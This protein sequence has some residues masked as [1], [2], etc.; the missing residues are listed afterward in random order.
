[1]KLKALTQNLFKQIFRFAR[2]PFYGKFGINSGVMLMNLTQM[3]A[4]K[5]EQQLL[6]IYEKY[7]LNLVFGDQ[8]IIN[9]YFHF[10]PEQLFLLPCEYNYRPDHCMYISFCK[11]ADKGIKLI[12]GNRGYFHKAENQPI[13]SQIYNSFQKV[14]YS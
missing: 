3:R 10:H 6:P 12:H 13:F 5:W 4:I 7:N 2:H 14:K 9:I 11:S 1:M 8:D